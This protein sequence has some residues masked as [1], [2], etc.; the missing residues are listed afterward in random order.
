MENWLCEIVFEFR[1]TAEGEM[2]DERMAYA[3]SLI[4]YTPLSMQLAER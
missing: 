4:I 3:V 2:K 1:E